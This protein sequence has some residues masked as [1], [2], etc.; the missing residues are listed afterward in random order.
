[1]ATEIGRFRIRPESADGLREPSKEEVACFL[2]LAHGP[3]I[4][5]SFHI[6]REKPHQGLDLEIN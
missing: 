6:D 4:L 2:A 3:C 1:L 5:V